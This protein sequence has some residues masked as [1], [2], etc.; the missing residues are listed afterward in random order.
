MSVSSVN[1]LISLQESQLIQMLHGQPARTKAEAGTEN[2]RAWMA[3][4]GQNLPGAEGMKSP[5]AEGV[6][7]APHEAEAAAMEPI[8]PA[9]SPANI[10]AL[11]LAMETQQSSLDTTLLLSNSGTG[12]GGRTLVDYLTSAETLS[13]AAN[14]DSEFS[15]AMP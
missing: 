5:A 10:T 11:L 13:D 2:R 6:E 15:A 1:N 4:G 9:L 12:P 14:D 7:T 8:D 3:A